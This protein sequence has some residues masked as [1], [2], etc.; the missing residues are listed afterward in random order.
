MVD[1]LDA[2]LTTFLRR[3]YVFIGCGVRLS[4]QTRR[5]IDEALKKLGFRLKNSDGHQPDWNAVIVG[6]FMMTLF[7]FIATLF[8]PM[9]FNG[10]SKLTY[11]PATYKDA[12]MWAC[13]TLCFHS[14]A[15]VTAIRLRSQLLRDNRWFPLPRNDVPNEERPIDRYIYVAVAA[16]FSGFISLVCYQ[17]VIYSPSKQIFVSSLWWSPLA[18]LTGFFIAY[19]FDT[20]T[21]NWMQ[22]IKEPFVQAVVMGCT[23]YFIAQVRLPAFHAQAGLSGPQSTD[24]AFVFLLAGIAALIGFSLGAY[25]PRLQRKREESAYQYRVNRVT[26]EA[27]SVFE[28]GDNANL[29]LETEQVLLNG[30]KPVDAIRTEDGFNDVLAEQKA[31]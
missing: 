15:A 6:L 10:S 19:Y 26:W 24:Q 3:L 11:L 16:A 28:N 5:E 31:A 18:G 13:G 9:L 14:A 29:W 2:E 25:L 20:K 22:S 7:V 27:Q 8:S 12:V 17:L 1:E 4:H 21:T 23:A 30:M